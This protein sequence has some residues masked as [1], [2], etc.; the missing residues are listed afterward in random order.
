[1]RNLGWWIA[2][3]L[4]IAA[5]G[6]GKAAPKQPVTV[7]PDAGVVHEE[8]EE[9]ADA[10]PAM[11]EVTGIQ[12][13]NGKSGTEVVIYG[14]AFT[15]DQPGVTVYF[16]AKL[17]EVTRVTDTEIAVIAPKGS[18]GDVVDV[19]VKFEP[20]GELRLSDAFSYPEE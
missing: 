6:G 15:K 1:M 12:P 10:A 7:A 14:Q 20:G 2:S 13:T 3:A 17:A 8:P 16:G 4:V 9:P 5:C 18:A 19:L 11:L